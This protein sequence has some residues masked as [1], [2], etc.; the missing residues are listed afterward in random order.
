[1]EKSLRIFSNFMTVGRD[2]TEKPSTMDSVSICR[3][4]TQFLTSDNFNDL[5]VILLL[6]IQISIHGCV[7]DSL[8]AYIRKLLFSKQFLKNQLFQ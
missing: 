4:K 7:Q 3:Q 2:L 5:V 6:F 1:M 8:I